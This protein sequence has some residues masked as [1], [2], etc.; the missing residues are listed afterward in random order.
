[1]TIRGRKIEDKNETPLCNT[2]NPTN[3]QDN[4]EP[5]ITRRCTADAQ[6]I[7][8]SNVETVA[9]H[10]GQTEHTHDQLIQQA[11]ATPT[12]MEDYNKNEHGI[13]DTGATENF[14]TPDA[15][16]KNVRKADPPININ[17]PNGTIVQSTHTCNMDFDGIPSHVT[18]G[19]IV[20]DL[21]QSLVSTRKFCDAGYRV[22]YTR[23]WCK[24]YKG[25]KVILKE[26]GVTKRANYGCC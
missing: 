15:P 11:H 21:K 18:E 10:K 4:R 24:V 5:R 17:L 8:A 16:V 25:K 20:P 26:G 9:T 7:V 3:T 23:K 1:M 2:L 12:S 14:L 19:H 22:E 13:S 6:T